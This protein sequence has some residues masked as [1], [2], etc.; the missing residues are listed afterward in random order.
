MVK[1]FIK[2]QALGELIGSEDD[3]ALLVCPSS[4]KLFLKRCSAQ[5]CL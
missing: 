1:G 5:I 3:V 2:G 4:G